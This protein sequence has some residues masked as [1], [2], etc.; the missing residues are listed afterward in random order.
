MA[1]TARPPVSLNVSSSTK[2]KGELPWQIV[3]GRLATIALSTLQYTTATKDGIK[4][5][6]YAFLAISQQTGTGLR[7]TL[8]RQTTFHLVFRFTKG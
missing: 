8:G 4:L 2:T 1:E 6:V 3:L 7:Y 5:L